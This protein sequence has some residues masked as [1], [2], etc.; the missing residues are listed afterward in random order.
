MEI[1]V[2]R[3]N[4]FHAT[5]TTQCYVE[6]KNI[7]ADTGVPCSSF[8]LMFHSIIRYGVTDNFLLFFFVALKKEH[9]GYP[10][11]GYFLLFYFLFL[12]TV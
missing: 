2:T 10:L 4:L 11:L 12:D 7:Y 9:I 3:H 5:N 1:F 6:Y 8:M